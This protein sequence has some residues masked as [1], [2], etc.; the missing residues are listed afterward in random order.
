LGVRL[1]NYT[2]VYY[3]DTIQPHL[4]FMD[5]SA[6][7]DQ[8]AKFTLRAGDTIITKDSETPDDIARSAYVPS[9]LPGV[10]CG[11]HLSMVRPNQHAHGAFI[12]RYFDTAS[13]RAYFH[14]SANGLTRVG[15]GQYAVDNAPIALPPF[16]E[17]T[18]EASYSAIGITRDQACELGQ[19]YEQNAIVWIDATGTGELDV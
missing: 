15:L 18:A 13:S 14:I 1:C 12:K 6:S 5:A 9:D 10:V 11:Y 3:N 16:H 19:K 8:I 7:D 17:Q 2:D 4:A